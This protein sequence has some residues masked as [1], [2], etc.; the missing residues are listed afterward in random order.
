MAYRPLPLHVQASPTVARRRR[1]LDLRRKLLT[2]G[3]R[4]DVDA[5]AAAIT[6]RA[7]FDAWLRRHLA[8]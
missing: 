8:R 4:V 1:L 5:V 6:R 7:A 2:P 3:G